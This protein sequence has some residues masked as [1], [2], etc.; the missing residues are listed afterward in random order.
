MQVLQGYTFMTMMQNFVASLRSNSSHIDKQGRDDDLPA[1]SFLRVTT[2]L[3]LSQALMLGRYP[4]A[5]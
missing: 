1:L 3:E 5:E 4:S 2:E